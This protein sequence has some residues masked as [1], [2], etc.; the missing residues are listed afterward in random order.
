MPKKLKAN[1]S[2]KPPEAGA[3]HAEIADWIKTVMPALQPIIEHLDR[4]IRKEIPGL[5]YAVKWKRAFYGL[6]EQGWVIQIAPYDV[7][8]NIVFFGGAKFDPA[9]P[10]GEGSRY[11]KLRSVDEA[12]APE[13]RDWIRQAGKTPG[14][15]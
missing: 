2:R 8:V 6:P 15:K 5:Q 1:S 9:P 13:I 4:T 12:K 3:S 11:V 14:W 7:S 10:L